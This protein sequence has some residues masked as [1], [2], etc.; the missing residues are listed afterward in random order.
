MRPARYF[1]AGAGAVIVNARGRVLAFE[2]ANVPGAWQFPQGGLDVDETPLEAMFR[3]VREETGLTRRHVRL[4]DQHPT[5]L[6]YEL[7]RRSQSK[8]TG[9]GQVQYWFYLQWKGDPHAVPEPPQDEFRAAAW[10]TPAEV[11]RRAVPFRRPVYEALARHLPKAA[12]TRVRGV[13]KKR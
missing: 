8:R 2:R 6:V 1:R 7:P 13:A 3:E 10:M 9:M 4:L 11:I 5:L 12:G